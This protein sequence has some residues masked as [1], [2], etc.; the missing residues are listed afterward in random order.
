LTPSI[1]ALLSINIFPI[2]P[3]NKPKGCYVVDH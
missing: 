1:A 2:I 3:D